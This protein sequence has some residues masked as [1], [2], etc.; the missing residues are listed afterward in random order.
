MSKSLT[1]FTENSQRG[2]CGELCTEL[3]SF[4]ILRANLLKEPIEIL[5]LIII[6][7]I[8][9]LLLIFYGSGSKGAKTCSSSSS[10]RPLFSFQIPGYKCHK[11]HKV[12]SWLK[13]DYTWFTFKPR[14]PAFKKLPWFKN[15]Q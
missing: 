1:L 3:Y 15:K 9:H 4:L 10:H 7:T 14:I 6:I 13:L 5:F 11:V 2:E 8:D 12:I